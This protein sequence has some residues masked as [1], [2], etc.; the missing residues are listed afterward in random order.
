MGHYQGCLLPIKQA[1][2]IR[3]IEVFGSIM[4]RTLLLVALLC[5]IA[6]CTQFSDCGSTAGN[7]Q[8][9]VASCDIPPCEVKSGSK[10]PIAITMTPS[11]DISQVTAGVY[12]IFGSTAVPWPGFDTNGC[13]YMTG[14]QC[15]L[16]AG[17]EATWTYEVEVQPYYPKNIIINAEFELLDGKEMQA[18]KLCTDNQLPNFGIRAFK[19]YIITNSTMALKL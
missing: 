12:A 11:K 3:I 13:K 4:N 10:F 15:P 7:V 16:K 6:S 2:T 1:R 18:C 5:G 17:E 14:E 19:L 8:F 9:K